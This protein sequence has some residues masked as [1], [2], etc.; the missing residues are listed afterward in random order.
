V[1]RRLAPADVAVVVEHLG[2]AR[3]NQGDGYYLVAWDGEAP[4]GHLHLAVTEPPE[5]Q[6]VE[7][8]EEYRG[9][10]VAT[11]L[12]AAAEAACRGAQSDRVRV[13]VG[14]GNLRAQ[15]LYAKLGYVDAGVP[16]RR[17]TGT[18]MIRTG[19]FEVDDTLLTLEKRFETP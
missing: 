9:R 3:L 13:T 17:V 12:I 15:S 7:V 6:D 19:P 14:V 16:P 18:V 5:L 10:G 1:I 2:L 8:R 11:A 4:T